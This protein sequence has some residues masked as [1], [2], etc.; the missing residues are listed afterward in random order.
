MLLFAFSKFTIDLRH[1]IASISNAYR[2]AKVYAYSAMARRGPKT[3][4]KQGP[5]SV[6][7]EIICGCATVV[8]GTGVDGTVNG[9]DGTE[10]CPDSRTEKCLNRSGNGA[11]ILGIT[12]F[13][14]NFAADPAQSAIA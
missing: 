9:M 7:R 8:I 1:S 11:E 2:V 13:L 14:S 12:V 6:G 5:E 3:G 4:S 10:K